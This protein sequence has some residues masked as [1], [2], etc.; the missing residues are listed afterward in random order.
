MQQ[1]VSIMASSSTFFWSTVINDLRTFLTSCCLMKSCFEPS[2]FL[3]VVHQFRRNSSFLSCRQQTL[4]LPGS[5]C[6]VLLILFSVLLSVFCCYYLVAQVHHITFPP[7][8]PSPPL[9]SPPPSPSLP[10]PF[11][12]SP[13]LP[14]PPLP[15]P[16]LPSPGGS[17]GRSRAPGDPDGAMPVE[18]KSVDRNLLSEIDTSA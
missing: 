14:S 5:I 18:V 7:P 12:S 3:K 9:P 10:S 16:P 4:F 2:V 17:R 15:S 1:F 8:L 13:P 6:F 11:L